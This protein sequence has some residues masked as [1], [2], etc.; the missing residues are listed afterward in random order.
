MTAPLSV[1]GQSKLLG[2][3]HRHQPG[4][5]DRTQWLSLHGTNF[6]ETMLRLGTEVPDGGGR[7]VVSSPTWT[8]DL[9]RAILA[10]SPGAAAA[11]ITPTQ[12]SWNEFARHLPEGRSGGESR[13]YDHRA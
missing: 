3:E 9:S 11:P 6:V 8:V 2:E 1:Y 12:F 13:A 4:S 7:P 5:P 10:P